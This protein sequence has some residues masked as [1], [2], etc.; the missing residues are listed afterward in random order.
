MQKYINEHDAVREVLLGLQGIE[1]ILF[2]WTDMSSSAPSFVVGTSTLRLNTAAYKSTA[3]SQCTS[4]NAPLFS[5][6]TLYSR[7]IFCDSIDNRTS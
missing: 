1:N 6:A 7:I 5:S 4:F 2:V 3:C